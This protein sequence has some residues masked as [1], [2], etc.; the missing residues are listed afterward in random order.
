MKFLKQFKIFWFHLE[1]REVSIDDVEED[2]GWVNGGVEVVG[3]GGGG[4][5]VVGGGGGGA[6]ALTIA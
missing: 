2:A 3:G 6:G 5:E 4:V 1:E